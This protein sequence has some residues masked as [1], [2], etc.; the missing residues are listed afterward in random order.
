M[1]WMLIEVYMMKVV[2]GL[3]LE[4]GVWNFV[5]DRIRIGRGFVCFIYVVV[6]YV[7]FCSLFLVSWYSGWCY[8]D[9]FWVGEVC[10]SEFVCCFCDVVIWS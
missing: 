3:Y 1:R 2:G 5:V 9:V 6:Y 8:G 10:W 4:M 7:F